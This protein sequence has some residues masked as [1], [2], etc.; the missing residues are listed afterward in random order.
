MV[1]GS[2]SGSIY[3][4]NLHS[5]WFTGSTSPIKGFAVWCNK[6]NGRP[7]LQILVQM[8]VFNRF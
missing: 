3:S 5:S 8:L 2:K 7:K 4:E 6:K 1:K